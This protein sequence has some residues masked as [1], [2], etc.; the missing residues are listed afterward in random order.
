MG[1]ASGVQAF[2]QVRAGAAQQ[3]AGGYNA[4]I[5]E[6]NATRL[7]ASARDAIRRGA[8]EEERFSEQGAQALGSQRAAF[9]ARGV[10]ASYGSPLDIVLATARAIELDRTTIRESAT[11]EADD[12]TVAA[13]N[14]RTGAQMSR[15]EGR[16]A[17]AASR[18]S[19]LGTVLNGGAGIY[20][21]RAEAA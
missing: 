21:Y 6:K 20:R 4:R 5:G 2:G 19:A 8:I 13:F 15:L 11:R 10:D 18:L 9:G 16:N 1:L 14:A 7:E 17:A 3:A 12:I